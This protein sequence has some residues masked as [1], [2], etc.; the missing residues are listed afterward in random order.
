MLTMQTLV[1]IA[2]TSTVA[3][4]ALLLSL[5]APENELSE[6]LLLPGN[7]GRLSLH[8]ASKLAIHSFHGAKYITAHFARSNAMWESTGAAGCAKV[9]IIG[10]D[11]RICK[12]NTLPKSLIPN[13]VAVYQLQGVEE[14][15]E[16][17]QAGKRAPV[18]PQAGKRAPVAAKEPV[19]AKKAKAS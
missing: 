9:L 14:P 6:S 4:A 15:V 7:K 11:T 8:I 10:A 3:Q 5:L 2:G 13:N 17:P 12:K 1:H 18:A 19:A 16:E